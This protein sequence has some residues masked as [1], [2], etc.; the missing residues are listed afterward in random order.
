MFGIIPST[1]PKMTRPIFAY[2]HG[3]L[4]ETLLGR[5]SDLASETS[6]SSISNKFFDL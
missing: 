6:T 1:A 4:Q 5:Y 2:Y 3:R